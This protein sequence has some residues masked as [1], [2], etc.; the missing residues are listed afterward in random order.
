MLAALAFALLPSSPCRRRQHA[1]PG[2]LMRYVRTPSTFDDSIL[3][4]CFD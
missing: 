4:P 2:Y 1:A 3:K